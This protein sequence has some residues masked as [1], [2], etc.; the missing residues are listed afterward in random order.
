[1]GLELDPG[2]VDTII[3]RWQGLF[4]GIA[5]HAVSG[6]AFDDLA[7]AAEVGDAA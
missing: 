4:G 1:M 5:R 6:R 7:G 2:Y 3:R